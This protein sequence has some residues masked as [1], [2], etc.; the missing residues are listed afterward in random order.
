[1]LGPIFPITVDA[2]VPHLYTLISGL[3]GRILFWREVT[4]WQITVD[5]S[6]FVG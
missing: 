4:V 6:W 1:V 5:G 3:V 2:E